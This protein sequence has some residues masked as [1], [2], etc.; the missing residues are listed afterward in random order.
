[1]K[2]SLI[3]NLYRYRRYIWRNAW[4]ELR[5]R[6]AGTGMGIFWNLLHPLV[7]I[8]TYTLVFSLLFLHRT[9]G[10]MSYR[11]YITSGVL[12]WGVFTSSVQ[13]GS[14]TF[15][16]HSRYLK[17]LSLPLEIF[18]A[19]I[20]LTFTLILHI[21]FCLFLAMS[22]LL[23]N[24]LQ[25]KLLLL[26]I[27]LVLLQG[28]ALGMALILAHLRVLFPDV[29][30]MLQA[31]ITLWRW[32]LPV[33]YPEE[34]LPESLRRWLFLNPPYVFLRSIRALILEHTLPGW[35]DWLIMGIWLFFLLGCGMIVTHKL[36]HDVRE[37]L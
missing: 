7:E 6:Y 3:F 8:L 13:R 22:A 5:H 29:K 15:I 14:N 12:T 16:E 26:P 21:Y 18:V 34:V 10:T 25:W 24:P 33:I 32:T 37:S 23:E 31:F 19:K 1:M 17:Q 27:F 4:S 9:S 35:R 11:L 36:Q 30:E 2:Y 28:L 20:V